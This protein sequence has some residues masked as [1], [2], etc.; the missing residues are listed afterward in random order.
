M[1]AHR[2]EEILDLVG[3]VAER[4]AA[5]RV[6]RALERV[7]GPED[8]REGVLVARAALD[9]EQGR[10]HRLQMLGGLGHEVLQNLTALGEEPPQIGDQ[11]RDRSGAGA[12]MD[13]SGDVS[14]AGSTTGRG[15]TTAAEKNMG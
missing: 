3:G 12:I 11:R 13:G 5:D 14:A 7:R 15:A 10:G 6:R 2:V 8:G 9:G 4:R 1:L